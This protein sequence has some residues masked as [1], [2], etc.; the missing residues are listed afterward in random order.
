MKIARRRFGLL[1]SDG[2]TGQRAEQPADLLDT[3]ECLINNHVGAVPGCEELSHL[4]GLYVKIFTVRAESTQAEELGVG[5]AGF[6]VGVMRGV[7]IQVR[8]SISSLLVE[9]WW[10]E[11]AMFGGNGD[12][13]E[14]N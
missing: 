11:L 4:V 6:G 1:L 12:A 8:V 2:G 7:E 5:N 3:L 14:F 10:S 9:H 13:Q